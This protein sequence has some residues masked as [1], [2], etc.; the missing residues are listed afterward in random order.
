MECHL[1]SREISCLEDEPTPTPQTI[2]S[3]TANLHW[4]W[5]LC[6]FDS[7]TF[8]SFYII[9]T[10]IFESL[11]FKHIYKLVIFLI[12]SNCT[13]KLNNEVREHAQKTYQLSIHPRAFQLLSTFSCPR[14]LAFLA[15]KN[16]NLFDFSRSS[17]TTRVSF[18]NLPVN[19]EGKRRLLYSLETWYQP[20][21]SVKIWNRRIHF[22]G[23]LLA[24]TFHYLGR[25]FDYCFL[26]LRLFFLIQISRSCFLLVPVETRVSS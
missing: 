9:S 10:T 1:A 8:T 12:Q 6:C 21:R 2:G 3:A 4:Y 7:V 17:I 13:M 23:W 14:N 11:Y 26:L 15:T 19:F 18:C 22:P 5:A 20:P 24:L 16:K 25:F